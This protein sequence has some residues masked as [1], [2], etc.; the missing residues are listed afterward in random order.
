MPSSV[1]KPLVLP[2]VHMCNEASP[3]HFMIMDHFILAAEYNVHCSTK[4]HFVHAHTH[5]CAHVHVHVHAHV[6]VNDSKIY[7]CVGSAFT[8][9][10]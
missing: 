2:D 9:H 7:M 5:A 10:V 6:H 3:Q 1:Y 4:L 8:F